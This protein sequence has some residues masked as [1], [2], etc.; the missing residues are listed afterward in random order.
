LDNNVIS[1]F[2]GLL[3][4]SKIGFV[5]RLPLPK[6]GITGVFV[7]G[8]L[9]A[10]FNAGSNYIEEFVRGIYETLNL[11]ISP[12][13]QAKLEGRLDVSGQLKLDFAAVMLLLLASIW[14]KICV[15]PIVKQYS[16]VEWSKALGRSE[17]QYVTADRQKQLQQLAIIS[18]Y[19]LTTIYLC[20]RYVVAVYTYL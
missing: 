9:I 20:G 7:A 16:I 12:A 5:E 10:A 2:E 8:T 13:F 15:P 1:F 19:V 18:T 4:W 3:R 14:H 17:V 6:I 11:E